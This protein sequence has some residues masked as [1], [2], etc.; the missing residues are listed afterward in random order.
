MLIAQSKL[1]S[2]LIAAKRL[3]SSEQAAEFL[4]MSPNTIRKFVAEGKIPAYHVGDKLV[5][6]DPEYRDHFLASCRVDNS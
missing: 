3:Q 5:K 1:K 6:F 4:G 2:L